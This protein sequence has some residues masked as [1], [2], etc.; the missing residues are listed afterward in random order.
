MQLVRSASEP[1]IMNA[2]RESDK[3]VELFDVDNQ[4]PRS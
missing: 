3:I 4:S 1:N 2:K